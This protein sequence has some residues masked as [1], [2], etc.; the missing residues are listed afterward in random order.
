MTFFVNRR[1]GF[2]A[3]TDGERRWRRRGVGGV[4]CGRRQ[5]VVSFEMLEISA[6]VNHLGYRMELYVSKEEEEEVERH[7]ILLS[8]CPRGGW[9][10]FSL[11]WQLS[12]L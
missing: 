1:Q 11:T 3:D 6:S 8:T 5:Q 2:P 10:S 12:Y 7:H 9:T 4:N